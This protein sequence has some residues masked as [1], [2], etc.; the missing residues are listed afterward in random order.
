MAGETESVVEN[1]SSTVH[2]VDRANVPTLVFLFTP[3]HVHRVAV[4]VLNL[5]YICESFVLRG[6]G[7]RVL[8][9]GF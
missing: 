6:F 4:G 1:L 8:V 9:E 2:E 3:R 5:S 7:G